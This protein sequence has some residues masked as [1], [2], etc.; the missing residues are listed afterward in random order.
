M[1]ADIRLAEDQLLADLAKQ[2]RAG[3]LT[4]LKVLNRPGKDQ[5]Q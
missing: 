2:D 3:F 1:R 4:A 5:T